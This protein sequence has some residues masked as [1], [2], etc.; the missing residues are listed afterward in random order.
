MSN[1]KSKETYYKFMSFTDYARLSIFMLLK[2]KSIFFAYKH[3]L[4]D[5]TDCNPSFYID[6]T[7]QDV[8][9]K[10]REA[11]NYETIEGYQAQSIVQLCF[12]RNNP[13]NPKNIEITRMMLMRALSVEQENMIPN[14]F[15]NYYMKK[16]I[17]EAKVFSMS[18]KWDEP[19]L[20]AHYANSHKG[21]CLELSGLTD[22]EHILIND[23]EYTSRR[24]RVSASEVFSDKHQDH[25]NE[26]HNK[27]FF[28]KSLGWQHE[29]EARIVI[30][31]E[32]RSIKPELCLPEGHY[33]RFPKIKVKSV[34]FGSNCS[35]ENRD[36]IIS[37]V[38]DLYEP[39]IKPKFYST[40]HNDENYK[41][42]IMEI[43]PFPF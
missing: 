6:L 29:N 42:E 26:V 25:L 17:N 39:K 11:S 38:N 21:F 2:H 31:D 19:R 33:I 16:I 15:L 7:Q 23:V 35:L 9:K 37:L 36:M 5:P 12:E 20:W 3:V 10:I 30:P 4:N 13:T 28:H 27:I 43:N 22:N 14:A 40:H 8:E 18:K 1:H 24:P 32:N 41:I 34:Y